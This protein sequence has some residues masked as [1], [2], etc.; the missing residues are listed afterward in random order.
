MLK[1]LHQN[2]T[3]LDLYHRVI[4]EQLQNNFIEKVPG[5]VDHKI[6]HYLPHHDV[7]KDSMTTPIRVVFNCSSRATKDVAS[8]NDCL[9]TGPNLTGKIGGMR[10][11]FRT[12]EYAYVADISKA[13][14][15]IGLKEGDRN[16]TK[17]LWPENPNDP[18]S[19]L[20]TYRFKSVLFGSCSS[21]F[22]LCSTLKHHFEKIK[23]SEI[24]N[25]FYMDNLQGTT[26]TEQEALDFYRRAKAYGAVAY[27]VAGSQC[28]LMMSKARVAPLKRRTLPQLELTALQV[29]TQLAVYLYKQVG[30]FEDV[31]IWT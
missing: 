10:L 28:R 25:T 30:D 3:H 11:K 17:Y 29:G 22:L 8:L 9:Y 18:D 26:E 2:Q 7:L 13:F 21:P 1:K 24:G 4:Q 14:L 6:G 15:R 27:Y 31:F 5:V 23:E 12:K 19:P 16:F 20:I